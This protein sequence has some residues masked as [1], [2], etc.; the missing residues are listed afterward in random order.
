MSVDESKAVVDVP[1]SVGNVIVISID[2]DCECIDILT[3]SFYELEIKTVFY[4]ILDYNN[5]LV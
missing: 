5:D 3:G 4:L 2:D 1:I